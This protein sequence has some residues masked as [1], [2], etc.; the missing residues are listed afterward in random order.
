MVMQRDVHPHTKR[1]AIWLPY[2]SFC[3]SLNCFNRII[4]SVLLDNL[5]ETF[6][7]LVSSSI[8][9]MASFAPNE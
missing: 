9:Q 8:C 5:D 3:N 2:Q 6:T 4:N 7:A 1:H